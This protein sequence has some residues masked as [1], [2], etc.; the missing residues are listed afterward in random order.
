VPELRSWLPDWSEEAL[1]TGLRRA[2]P[3][4]ADRSL[5]LRPKLGAPLGIFCRSVARVGSDLMVK[6]TWSREASALLLGQARLIQTLAPLGLPLQQPILVAVDP[7]LVVY[8]RL[9]GQELT[10]EKARSLNAGEEAAVA[11]LLGDLLNRL[12]DPAVLAMLVGGGIQ[13]PRERTWCQAADTGR[14]RRDLLLRLDPVRV[15]RLEPRL[16]WVDQELAAPVDDVFLHGDLHGHNLLFD[17]DHTRLLGVLDLESAS[18]GDPAFDFRYLPAL[19]PR[20][21]LFDQVV[22]AYRGSVRVERAWAWH[23]LTDLGDALWRTEQD[24]PVEFGPLPRRVDAL[25]DR[26]MAAGV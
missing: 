7:V 22:E 24:A 16:D 14:I 11:G 6:A 8:R 21:D 9:P 23:L 20:L 17:P 19:S 15:Q 2:A 18:V 1:R 5:E 12:H 25:L 4:L 13:L 3:D 10:S 26:L